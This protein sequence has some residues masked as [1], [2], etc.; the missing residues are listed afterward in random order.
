M[1]F[2]LFSPVFNDGEFIPSEYTCDGVN[3]SPPLRWANPPEGTKS[4]ALIVD[5]PDAPAG[6]WVHWIVFNIPAYVLELPQNCSP[7]HLPDGSVEGMNDFRRTNYGGPCPPSGTHRYF[8][9]FYA[10]DNLLSLKEGATKK[11]LLESMKEHILAKAV[12]TGRY[13]RRS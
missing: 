7:E 3:I 2:K 5:D 1:D 4:F 13:K 9:K 10:L 6:D 8:F 12:L 11:Q